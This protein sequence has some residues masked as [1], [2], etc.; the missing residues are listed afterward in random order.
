MDQII[1]QKEEVEKVVVEATHGMVHEKAVEQAYLEHPAPLP[2]PG[3]PRWERAMSEGEQTA[4]MATLI[5][6]PTEVKK[7]SQF[8]HFKYLSINFH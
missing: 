1:A 4:A 7:I 2:L 8:S 5:H 3:D 6:R